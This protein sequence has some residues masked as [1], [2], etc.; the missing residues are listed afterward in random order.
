[1]AQLNSYDIWKGENEINSIV[2][3]SFSKWNDLAAN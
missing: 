3:E 2:Y 1:M